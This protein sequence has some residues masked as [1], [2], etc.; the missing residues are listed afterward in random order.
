MLQYTIQFGKA[1]PPGRIDL[2]K[3]TTGFRPQEMKEFAF[4]VR[5]TSDCANTAAGQVTSVP[6]SLE[7]ATC[8]VYS[9]DIDVNPKAA[10]DYEV[11]FEFL[12]TRKLG[13]PI[14]FVNCLLRCINELV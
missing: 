10:D 12:L 4:M 11:E 6:E 1:Y 2:L 9:I 5:S 14:T 13:I 3:S 7:G 8:Q